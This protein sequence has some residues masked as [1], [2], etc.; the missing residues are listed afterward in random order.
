MDLSHYIEYPFIDTSLFYRHQVHSVND[1][2]KLYDELMNII[3][4]FA[5][6]GLIHCDFNEFNILLKEDD[7]PVVIDFPQ[8]ISTSHLN[9]SRSMYYYT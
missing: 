4:K 9:A 5:E 7:S 3:V 8:M 2:G 6:L 1:P